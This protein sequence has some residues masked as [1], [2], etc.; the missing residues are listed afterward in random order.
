MAF[1]QFDTWQ[2]GLKDAMKNLTGN[3]EVKAKF[4]AKAKNNKPE[5][6]FDKLLT[7][8]AMQFMEHFFVE[9]VFKPAFFYGRGTGVGDGASN[10][11][12][13]MPKIEMGYSQVKNQIT[14]QRG[15]KKDPFS[16]YRGLTE[17][18][19]EGSSGETD[20][21]KLSAKWEAIQKQ[22]QAEREAD[23]T[24]QHGF[25]HSL[26]VNAADNTIGNSE[27]FAAA[28]ETGFGQLFAA[29][30]KL[31]AARRGGH[32]IRVDMGP[33]AQ[34]LQQTLARY[35]VSTGMASPSQ[36]DSFFY[37]AEF[38]TGIAENVGGA[39][40]I[41]E[42]KKNNAQ[43]GPIKGPAGSWWF[44]D[45]QHG[46]GMWSGQRGL[47]FLF[48]KATR[49]P[50]PIYRDWIARNIGPKFAAFMAVRTNGKVRAAR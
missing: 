24:R 25:A 34:V 3:V 1:N 17:A 20:P 44:G 13:F 33:S 6:D 19:A 9:E 32:S 36:F 5:T 40:W 46:G 37:A 28:W 21:R 15:K 27:S 31:G 22:Q 14:Y 48:D 49:E 7:E 42:I 30:T 47:H 41:R 18:L 16:A 29:M 26:A 50:L 43:N 2:R 12:M 35:S 45:E 11:Y 38:G 10:P 4:E 23:Y 39:Q 8:F